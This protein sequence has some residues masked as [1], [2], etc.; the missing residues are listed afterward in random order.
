MSSFARSK[1]AC[2]ADLPVSL[3][4]FF[5]VAPHPLAAIFGEAVRALVKKLLTSCACQQHKQPP[6]RVQ[7]RPALRLHARCLCS[8]YGTLH[9]ACMG[10]DFGVCQAD[11]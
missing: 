7:L 11:L 2:K 10:R 6:H 3:Q 8:G 9:C 1:Y 4:G 5:L